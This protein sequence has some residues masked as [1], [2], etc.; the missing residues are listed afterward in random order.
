MKE[1]GV[2]PPKA[3][4]TDVEEGE[5]PNQLESIRFEGGEEPG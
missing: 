2:V 3:V 5:D 4:G 1:L